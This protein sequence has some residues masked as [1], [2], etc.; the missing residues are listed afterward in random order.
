MGQEDQ[1]RVHVNVANV[2]RS[3]ISI[4]TF[5]AWRREAAPGS[6]WTVSR[7]KL[8]L[9]GAELPYRL[10]GGSSALWGTP[11]AQLDSHLGHRFGRDDKVVVPV[12]TPDKSTRARI[13][14]GFGP[15]NWFGRLV[16]KIQISLRRPPHDTRDM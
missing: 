9:V 3:E 13:L 7:V 1:R 12:G 15:V 16:E 6:Q 5:I 10:A 14:E 2:G 11:A 4:E 8:E